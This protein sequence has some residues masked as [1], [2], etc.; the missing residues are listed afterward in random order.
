[1]PCSLASL[2]V[3][4]FREVECLMLQ[5]PA[6]SHM[7][8]SEVFV[9]LDWLGDTDC[10]DEGMLVVCEIGLLYTIDVLEWLVEGGLE[11]LCCLCGD[12]SP[13]ML[14]PHNRPFVRDLSR[15]L[16]DYA[17]NVVP[18]CYDC[19]DDIFSEI[20]DNGFPMSEYGYAAA[21]YRF[22][23]KARFKDRLKSNA[24]NWSMIRFDPRKP[25]TCA[26]YQAGL[27]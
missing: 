5:E 3:L 4:S 1:M 21:L 25:C 13:Q 2:G 22:I 17:P 11:V 15:W 12:V 26:T 20:K 14:A 18:I 27:A 8:A 16:T 23:Q 19:V 7:S 6:F 9:T 24:D 10:D